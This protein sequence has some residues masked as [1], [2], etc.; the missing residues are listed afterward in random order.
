MEFL[1]NVKF[2]MVMLG[3]FLSVVMAVLLEATF[4]EWVSGF[5]SITAIYVAGTAVHKK[6]RKTS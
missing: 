3:I 4:T 6:V 5:L 2:W 1:K